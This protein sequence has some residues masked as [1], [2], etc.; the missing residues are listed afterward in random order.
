VGSGKHFQLG[1]AIQQVV[2]RLFRGEAEEAA[3]TGLHLKLGQPPAREVARPDIQH[4]AVRH[5]F[6]ERPP[7]LFGR[8]VAVEV[9]HLIQ[10]DMVCLQPPE[11]IGEVLAHFVGRN[12]GF[13]IGDIGVGHAL[14]DLGGEHDLVSPGGPMRE[15]AADDRL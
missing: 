15:P 8:D 13:F 2:L 7:K 10:V 1:D 5:Q 9:M 12:A 6:F 4:V 11:R 3:L 14:V